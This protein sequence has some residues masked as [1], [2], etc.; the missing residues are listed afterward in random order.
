MRKILVGIALVVLAG[1]ATTSEM[2]LAPNVVRLDTQ[3]SGALFVGSAPS[4]TM[5]KAAEAT[6]AR[7][8]SHFRLEQATMASGSRLVGMQTQTSG[9]GTATVYGN[10]AYG[11]YNGTSFSTPVYARTANI[12][13]T[14]IM[15]HAN[16][17][18][19]RGAF[20]AQQVLK[21]GG[22]I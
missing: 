21:K 16:E 20:D 15:F 11:T 8:Y 19:S 7:G 14:V 12:G 22:K 3:A 10:N 13:V 1:C 6:L 18:G 4:I 9:V 5:K 17:A 2:P